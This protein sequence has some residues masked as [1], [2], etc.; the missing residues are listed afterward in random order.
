MELS[1]ADRN[2]AHVRVGIGAAVAFV[3]LV[4]VLLATHRSA[5]AEPVTAPATE[6]RQ[7][8]PDPG[9]RPRG[10]GGARR[11]GGG[12]FDPGGEPG[13]GFAPIPVPD[14]PQTGGTTT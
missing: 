2:R 5:A 7:T 3:A 8:V 12:G 4:L 9:H 13:P 11:R 1:P 14:A 6:Q 10:E